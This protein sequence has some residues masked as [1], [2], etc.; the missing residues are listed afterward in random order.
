MNTNTTQLHGG[1][2]VENEHD[3]NV[4]LIDEWEDLNFMCKHYYLS[5]ELYKLSIYVKMHAFV[6]TCIHSG[7]YHHVGPL[8]QG[9]PGCPRSAKVYMLWY[10]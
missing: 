5:T 4:L 6:Q 1:Q 9:I 10:G 2:I 7:M 8:R 3:A